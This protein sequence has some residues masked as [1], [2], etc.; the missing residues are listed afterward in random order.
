M[1]CSRLGEDGPPDEVSG[2]ALND[3][4]FN[5][6]TIDKV[7]KHLMQYGY[8]I[9]DGER[10]AKTI[11]FAK[12]A[13]M[14]SDCRTFQSSLSERSGTYLPPDRLL[15][16]IFR[17]AGRRTERT[18][19]ALRIAVSVDMLDTGIDIPI[20]ANLV[21]FKVVRSKSKF[22]QM[23]G[24]GTRL[25]PDLFATGQN[26]EDFLVFDF[27]ENFQFFNSDVTI[28]ESG[29][30]RPLNARIFEARVKA[31]GLLHAESKTPE[32][33]SVREDKEAFAGLP[34]ALKDT[35]V[36]QLKNRCVRNELD[37]FIVR[38]QRRSVEKFQ[39]EQAWNDLSEQDR[40]E[41]IEN[42]SDIPTTVKDPDVDAKRFDLLC[43]QIQLGLLQRQDISNLRKRM[44]ETIGSWKLRKAFP[45][46]P[47]RWRSFRTLV[48]RNIERRD[49]P[50]DRTC[51]PQPQKP[52]SSDRQVDPQE[53]DNAFHRFNWR[54]NR[55][56][57]YCTI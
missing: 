36:G 54:S 35:L 10:I 44:Q 48:V 28:K 5:A 4:L 31:L 52:C 53:P 42:L 7:L 55:N 46:S 9:D 6:D 51:S 16:Q 39:N 26:K 19:S 21:F 13:T 25:S 15:N 11:I 45:M 43:L 20:V 56:R 8:H 37:N 23:I 3:W 2:A 38:T 47:V 34:E 32:G 22:W 49:A 12:N 41:L 29:G 40:N 18:E 17:Y 30:A 24:R 50:D 1:G 33:K 57:A 27:L 14:Q